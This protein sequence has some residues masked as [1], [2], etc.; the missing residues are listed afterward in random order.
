MDF[1]IFGKADSSPRAGREWLLSELV[2]M[3][4]EQMEEFDMARQTLIDMGNHIID[5]GDEVIVEAEK[6]MSEN[7]TRIIMIPIV[8]GQG[9]TGLVKLCRHLLGNPNPNW[10]LD[11]CFCS[12]PTHL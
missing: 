3:T 12:L 5:L 1:A 2:V 9:N 11:H 4:I 10:Q 6:M 8:L 7:F